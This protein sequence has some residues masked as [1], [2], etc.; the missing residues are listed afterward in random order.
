M[1]IKRLTMLLL[2]LLLMKMMTVIQVILR[3]RLGHLQ[4]FEPIDDIVID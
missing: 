4:R 2:L 1:V 3:V